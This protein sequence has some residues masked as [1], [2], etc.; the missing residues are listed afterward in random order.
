MKE[1]EDDIKEGLRLLQSGEEK[2]LKGAARAAGVS[3]STLRGRLRGAT[4][5]S[6]ARQEQQLI[7]PEQEKVLEEY[8][9]KL[10]SWG[11]PLKVSYLRSYAKAFLNN[12]KN[13]KLGDHWVTRF[14]KRHPDL[15][16]AFI[17][18]IDKQRRDGQDPAALKTFY[19]KVKEHLVISQVL[20]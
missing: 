8:C 5:R 7:S 16:S 10:D 15:K 18:R 3:Y 20:S 13:S 14:L 4:T 19:T 17:K 12:E 1:H 9:L 2:T 11:F 6:K